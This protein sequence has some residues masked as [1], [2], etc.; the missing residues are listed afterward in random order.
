MSCSE[1][2]RRK[3]KC[4]RQHPCCNCIKRE[5]QDLCH[6]DAGLK[7]GQAT[8]SS[9]GESGLSEISCSANM[10]HLCPPARPGPEWASELQDKIRDFGY[11]SHGNYSSMSLLRTAE[12]YGGQENS[13]V[14]F[15][16]TNEPSFR[17]DADRKYKELVRQLPSQACV[18]I[19]VQTFFS[20]INWQYDLLDEESF[21][22][23]LE[24]W[25]K[26]SYSDLQVN[27]GRLALETLVFPAL[28]FQVLAHALLF[29]PP[30]DEKINSLMTMAGMT[31][32]DLGAEYS[33]TGTELL[34]LLGKKNINVA[35]VQAGLL[36]A[37]F[38]EK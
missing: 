20:G 27:F 7:E 16:A 14:D 12:L 9:S 8:Q 2:H 37:F 31:F 15:P 3:Q 32:H 21:S 33:D 5:A 17:N 36:R 28:L 13:L 24:A 23:R 10:V 29:H 11:S 6:Y 19:L 22:E 1:C 34:A 18:H 25:G 26:I 4:D 38:F 30:H 35:M